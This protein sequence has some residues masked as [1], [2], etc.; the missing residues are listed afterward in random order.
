[1]LLRD[2]PWTAHGVVA[3]RV[4]WEPR[5]LVDWQRETP[6]MGLRVAR[7]RASGVI[8]AIIRILFA[9]VGGEIADES[10]FLVNPEDVQG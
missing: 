1:M 8:A 4:R 5:D 2:L 3:Y 7:K 6:S 10:D 9:T